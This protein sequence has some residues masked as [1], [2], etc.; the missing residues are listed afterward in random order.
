MVEA[1]VTLGLL[2]LEDARDAEALAIFERVAE[3][4]YADPLA[5]G[6]RG[7]ALIRLGREQ[8]GA[9]LL[10]S[11][12]EQPVPE[13]LLYYE[14]GKL[15]ERSDAPDEARRYYRKGLEVMLGERAAHRGD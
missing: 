9:E 13:P 11:A 4:G 2:M 6:A 3:L 10:R 5:S 14:M 12:L 8:E 7:V 15:S 1:G